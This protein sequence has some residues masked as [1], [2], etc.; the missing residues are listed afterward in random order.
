VRQ[1][2]SRAT[3]DLRGKPRLFLA[4]L[5]N[6]RF[7]WLLLAVAG[8][9]VI[10][11]FAVTMVIIP[12]LHQS[13]PGD[14]AAYVKAARLIHDGADPYTS[15]LSSHSL[16]P[17]RRTGY[18]YPPLLAWLLSPI[19]ALPDPLLLTSVFILDVLAL[20][21]F[22]WLTTRSLQFR[23]PQSIV[24]I[25]VSTFAFFPV[26][27][28]FKWGQV[29]LLLL[30][31]S[32]L[33]FVAWVE[34]LDAIGGVAL[35]ISIALKLLQAPVLLLLV[36]TKRFRMAA[37]SLLVVLVAFLVASPQLLPEYFTRVLPELNA[38]TGY[39]ANLAP[40]AFFSRLIQP[41]NVYANVEAV[42][43]LAR[44]AAVIASTAAVLITARA[45][46]L[47]LG[48]TSPSERSLQ[49]ACV[50]TLSPLVSTIDWPAH[51]A[52]LL[53]PMA[54]L[55]DWSL[56][57]RRRG[58][59]VAVIVSWLAL[60]PVQQVLWTVADNPGALSAFVGPIY[61]SL[62]EGAAA[63]LFLMWGAA[64][65]ALEVEATQGR[66]A[67][68]RRFRLGTS[69]AVPGSSPLPM[70]RPPPPSATRSSAARGPLEPSE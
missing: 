49:A 59:A 56:R 68:L 52:L 7:R 45:I 11:A 43:Q 6:A 61:W 37:I 65:L 28:N 18:I 70:H 64:T 57:R 35:G 53:I 30:A 31:L 16:D 3:Q 20:T 19:S 58:F 41:Q 62:S 55:F 44:V 48:A 60:G 51:M 67:F 5:E 39:M 21:A 17:T 13:L 69:Q 34:G 50:L 25:V 15:W 66:P 33:W 46:L 12:L 8:A 36:L 2:E 23:G 4:S 63:A 38:S 24:L 10:P 42:P 22:W 14:L 40:I 32:S 29:N 9:A 1:A 26:Q 27:E 47:S 54:V